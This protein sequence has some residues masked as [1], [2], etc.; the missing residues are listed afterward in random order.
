MKLQGNYQLA[1][2]LIRFLKVFLTFRKLKFIIV[3]IFVLKSKYKVRFGNTV[4]NVGSD[5]SYKFDRFFPIVSLFLLR[6]GLYFLL[7][8]TTF[9]IL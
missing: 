2:I 5:R 4:Q 7:V 1:Q 3:L 6:A 8:A 9:C